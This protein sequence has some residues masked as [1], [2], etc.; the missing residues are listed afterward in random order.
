MNT[1]FSTIKN[2]L[3]RLICLS[4]VSILLFLSANAQREPQSVHLLLGNPTNARRD[5]ANSADNYLLIKP[6]FALSYNKS[7]GGANWVAWHTEA[8]DL[9]AEDRSNDF[10]PDPDLPSSWRIR[11]TAYSGT[12]YDRGH[13]CP[14]GDRTKDHPSNS[15]TFVMSNMLPQT[16]DLNRHIWQKLEAY[17]RLLVGRKNEVYTIAGGYGSKKTINGGR[18]NVPERFWKVILILPLG[19]DDL[20]RITQRTRV[21]A[22]EMPNEAGIADERWQQYLTTVDEIEAKTGFDFLTNLSQEIERTLESKKDAGRARR[23]AG[24]DEEPDLTGDV[25]GSEPTAAGTMRAASRTGSTPRLDDLSFDFPAPANPGNQKTLWATHYYV[26][27]DLKSEGEGVPLLDMRGRRLGPVLSP[28]DWCLG[29]VEGTFRIMEDNGAAKVFN[30]AGT[31]GAVQVD[32]SPFIRSRSI[33]ITALGRS[34]YGI[35]K[36]P[37][38]DGVEGMILVPYRTIAVDP[39]FIPYGSLVYIP[40]AHGAEILLPSGKRAKHDGYFYAA[41]TGGAIKQNHI[42]VFGGIN[43]NNPFPAF[44]KNNR[45]RTFEAFVVADAAINAKLKELHKP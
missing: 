9:G 3:P 38:G 43:R 31:R 15:A 17:A 14:S 4:L 10:R 19:D 34:R 30:F 42:D 24:E 35:A 5:A 40:A 44:I 36:G 41:D 23:A 26:Y 6:Q 18:V 2:S 27:G 16:A 33:N 37:F 20:G 29:G 22:V 1:M 25:A 13:I 12:G 7:K 28:R 8:L 45:S 39:G 32:C 11:P 21:I